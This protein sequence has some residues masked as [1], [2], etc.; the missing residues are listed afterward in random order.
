MAEGRGGR[1]GGRGRGIGGAGRGGGP[2][3]GNGS[4]Q[5][6]S[7]SPAQLT[8]FIKNARTVEAL[9]QTC[10]KH[11]NSLNHIHL[12]ACWNS[13]GHLARA[14]GPSW[15]EEN[16]DSLKLLAER[17]KQI[18][19]G[20]EIRARQLA[21]IAHGVARSGTGQSMKSLVKALAKAI[22]RCLH[23]CNAQELANSAWAFAKA[24]YLDANLFSS[25]ARV[26][27]SRANDFNAQELANISWAFATANQSDAKLF[28]ALSG[29]IQWHLGDFSAQGLANTSWAFAKVGHLD[30]QL[31]AAMAR[32]A[33]QLM[34]TFNAQDLAHTAWA[35]AKVGHL[36]TKLF[37]EMARSAEQRVADFNAQ[38][39][40]NTVWAFAKA[41]HVDAQLFAS[42]ARSIERRLDDF[43]AQ[44][45]ANTVWAFVKACHMDEQLLTALARSAEQRLGDFNTQDLVNTAWAFAKIGHA[46]A[47][48]F[49]ALARAME[50]RLSDFDA[51]N[52]ANIAWAFAKA[53]QL[54]PQLFAALA[55]S[56]TQRVGDFSAQDL[57]NTAWAFANAG[58]MDSQLFEALAMSA[59]QCIADLEDEEVDNMIWAFTKA[60]QQGIVKILRLQKDSQTSA[61]LGPADVSGCGTIVVAGG[62]IGGAA[63]AVALQKKGF[64]VVVLEG[65]ASFDSRKQGYGLTIQKLDAV[66]ALGIDLAQDDA[67][68]TSH[69]TFSS[70][71]HI[72]G[73][74]GEMFGQRKERADRNATPASAGRFIH[75]PRQMLRARILEQVRPG[76]IRWNTR[77]KSFS[78]WTDEKDRSSK[79]KK[80]GV[81][82]TLTDGSTIDAAALVGSDGIFSTVRRQLDLP[83]DRLNYLGL[84]VVLGI[85]PTAAADAGEG[86]KRKAD[87]CKFPLPQRR[88]FETVDGV[89]RIYAMPFTTTVTMWQ[90]SFPYEEE[91]AR[92]LVKD[93]AA[94]KEEILRRCGGWHEPIPEL[95]RSTPLDSMSGYP[96]YDREPLDANILRPPRAK[97]TKEGGEPRPER[98]VTVIGDAA[99]P[100][101]PFRAQGA[102]QALTDAVLLAD[103]L[104]ASVRRHGPHAGFD[105][106]LPLF[107]HKMLA[108]S[109]RMVVQSREKAREMHSSLAM[110]PAR[111][112]QRDAGAVDMTERIRALRAKGVGAHNANDPRGLDAVVAEVMDGAG[113]ASHQTMAE[114]DRPS[115]PASKRPRKADADSWKTLVIEGFTGEEWAQWYERQ[116]PGKSAK[117]LVP[118]VD[119][120]QRG[121]KARAKLKRKQE[122]AAKQE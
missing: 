121:T 9:F 75:I 35:F 11:A 37:Q 18:A 72:L 91:A 56:I 115:E 29:S 111:K 114:T 102:N 76:T 78:C 1:G 58:Q 45:L 43:N 70:E 85:V 92:N 36:D 23:D 47:P 60:G 100:L 19:S 55:T 116:A 32:S 53:G 48:L 81:T 54:D 95:L 2:D 34:A 118:K 93:Q 30:A 99:H 42:L 122:L 13:L 8:S 5:T 117:P 77:L 59:E 113:E 21:N 28:S 57:A 3:G 88:I 86:K 96:T 108:R 94:L 89:T 103:T 51:Q 62:G 90:L 12:S 31:F 66:Q 41:G 105:A 80:N 74:F 110:Q 119:K 38:G 20:N 112:V 82:A 97:A 44:D 16:A 64:E 68:S 71:G 69:Y 49:S 104:E 40:A 83:G 15:S 87:G 61:A 98:R 52:L 26:V 4:S 106:A 50:Q 7:V 14:A 120:R 67:P 10:T 109:A 79:N 6:G 39:L 27:E 107:E 63:L 65:D 24:G 22:E 17:T 73:V 84:V 33:E 25:L 101:S 46:D